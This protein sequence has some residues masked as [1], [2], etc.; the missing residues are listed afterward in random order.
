MRTFKN[1]KSELKKKGAMALTA[2]MLCGSAGT[3]FAQDTITIHD[4]TTGDIASGDTVSG[5]KTLGNVKTVTGFQTDIA[6]GYAAEIEWDEMLFI[7]DRGTFDPSTGTLVESSETGMRE[8]I[9]EE[10]NP[11]GEFEEISMLYS[12]AYR[13]CY[14]P[15]HSENGNSGYWYSTGDA[16]VTVR[17]LSTNPIYTKISPLKDAGNTHI[18][19]VHFHVYSGDS[20][21]AESGFDNMF[22]P[23]NAAEDFEEDWSGMVGSG[24]FSDGSGIIASEKYLD[25]YLGGLTY[26]SDGSRVG[27]PY[28]TTAYVNLYGTPTTEFRNKTEWGNDNRT[29]EKIGEIVINFNK[30]TGTDGNYTPGEELQALNGDAV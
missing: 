9:D 5:D 21:D 18:N 7:Y 20:I 26:N 29:G 30:V 4:A 19:D 28:Y 17:N 27:D 3:A 23:L 6:E 16:N 25:C 22:V 13:Q 11:T 14:D 8:I 1:W 12:E 24:Y 15:E 2:F 10:G